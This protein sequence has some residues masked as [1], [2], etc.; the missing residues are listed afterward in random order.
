SMRDQGNG[1]KEFIQIVL[2]NIWLRFDPN[3][4]KTL[5]HNYALD[6]SSRPLPITHQRLLTQISDYKS[7][8]KIRSQAPCMCPMKNLLPPSSEKAPIYALFYIGQQHL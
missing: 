4:K 3:V 2:V 6:Q 7:L 5:H 1:S 8:I